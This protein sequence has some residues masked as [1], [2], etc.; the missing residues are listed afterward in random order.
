MTRKRLALALSAALLAATGYI[1]LE[2]LM[3]GAR[4]DDPQTVIDTRRA[5][6]KD[7]G[8]QMKAIYAVVDAKSGDMA[9]MQKRALQVQA[10]A[11][12][13]PNLFPAGT[14][15]DDFSGKTHALPAIWK[16]MDRFKANA[17]DLETQAGKLAAAAQGGDMAAFA[18]QFAATGKVCGSCHTDFRAKLN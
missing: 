2:G 15:S 6:M 4:A 5:T 10:D 13:I 14:S 1:A 18:A 16:D 11:A 9:D 8:A 17:A 7:I 3:G 12:K